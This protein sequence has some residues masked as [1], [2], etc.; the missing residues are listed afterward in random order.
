MINVLWVLILLILVLYMSA[1]L[2][3][4]F[5]GQ[6]DSST[7]VPSDFAVHLSAEGFD[8]GSLFG[9]IPRGIIT[10]IGVMTYDNA[11]QLQR[12]IGEFYPSAWLFF[13]CFMVTVSIG[14]MELMTSLFIESLLEEKRRM[15]KMQTEEKLSARKNVENL[16]AALFSNFDEDGNGELDQEELKSCMAVFEDRDTKD[17]MEYVGI[18]S[19]MMKEAIKVA[20]I[21]ADGTVSEKEFRLALDSTSAV[22]VKADI[23]AVHQRVA[24]L[25]KK[26]EAQ[27]AEIALLRQD[28]KEMKEILIKLAA[29]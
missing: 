24:L 13:G 4:N 14:M 1:V 19:D 17:L 25:A 26:N 9:T 6:S 2:T 16:L 8:L 27:S 28:V 22:P 21:D 18:D 3:K 5:F 10:L 7:G 11:S 15:E 29:K 20:D 12:A 23:R